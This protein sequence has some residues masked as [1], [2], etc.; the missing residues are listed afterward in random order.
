MSVFRLINGKTKVLALSLSDLKKLFS[1]ITFCKNGQKIF[2]NEKELESLGV[3]FATSLFKINKAIARGI[4]SEKCF[5]Y[6][7]VFLLA[8]FST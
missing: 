3:G 6:S 5:Y 2:I 1:Q 8:S 4:F 7:K